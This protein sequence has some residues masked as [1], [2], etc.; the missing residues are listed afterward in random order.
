MR[1]R[2]TLAYDG[3]DFEGW[4]VQ[5]RAGARTV[6]GHVQ[7]ALAKLAGGELIEVAGAGRTDTGVHALGQVASFDL[8]R[9]IESRDLLA[10]LN[11]L[12]PRDVRVIE[13]ARVDDSFH[14]RSSAISKLYRYEI[15]A[16]CVQV[17]TRRRYS[18]HVREP[19]DLDA[20]REAAALYVGERDFASVASAGGSVK[21]TVREV[22]RSELISE[23]DLLRYEVEATGFLRK[24]VRS[25]V[26]GL[27][28]V[29]NGKTTVAQLSRAL[30][31]RDRQGWPP[32][33][34]ARGLTLVRVRYPRPGEA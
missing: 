2:I 16:C 21:T 18:A 9:A 3:T 28:A 12:L 10:A 32:P 24:M 20:M 22:F 7:A 8:D 23:G 5:G 30:E 29:G 14:A 6:Q 13:A 1:F 34:V 17:P 4:Q 25:L 31:A 27:I 15:D 19:L 26:G 33:A 11:G